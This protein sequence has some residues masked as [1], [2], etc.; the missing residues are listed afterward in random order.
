MVCW[1]MA[2]VGLFKK[3]VH[4]F[5]KSSEPTSLGENRLNKYLYQTTQIFL[6]VGNYLIR[7]P[8]HCPLATYG[9]LK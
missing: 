7:T 9:C 5:P 2:V 4:I 1:D 8:P 6:H 3:K